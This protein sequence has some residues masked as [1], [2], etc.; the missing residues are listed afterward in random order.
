MPRPPID[1]SR[2]IKDILGHVDPLPPEACAP[3]GHYERSMSDNWNLLQYLE[4]SLIQPNLKA[5]VVRRHLDRVNGMILVSMIESFER[6]LKEVAAVCVDQLAL[7][8]LDV[9]FNIFKLQ[10]ATLAAHFGSTTLGKSLCES[11]IWL[12]CKEINDRFQ[13]LLAGLIQDDKSF[14]L[15]P[16]KSKE[17]RT[18]FET[19]SILWQLRHTA[20][21]NVGVLTQSD[22]VKL[23]LLLREP[24]EAPRILAPTRD[25]IRYLKRFLDEI[26]DYCN[27][28]IGYRLAELITS[29]HQATPVL[30]DAQQ[31][32]DELSSLF[33]FPVTI[34]NQTGSIAT[35]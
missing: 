33:A 31:K 8:V 35:V 34:S 28:R 9:R 10:G 23:R 13:H 27:R 3:F 19:L 30:F 2:K 32:A 12:N 11:V 5:V 20:V 24:V 26:A 17:D 16:Q 6:Y 29:I 14:Q 4:R 22:A 21:H 25:D 7:F 1:L 18:R 15:L